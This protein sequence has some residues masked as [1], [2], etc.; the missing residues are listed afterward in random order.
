[1]HRHLRHPLSPRK[2][3]VEMVEDENGAGEIGRKRQGRRCGTTARA[4]TSREGRAGGVWHPKVA[5][6]GVG[7]R[8]RGVGGSFATRS[9]PR[10]FAVSSAASAALVSKSVSVHRR[11]AFARVKG[12]RGVSVMPA[13]AGHA[14]IEQGWV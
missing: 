6:T 5:R 9:V 14:A 4:A 1:M 2:K 3:W 12:A 13:A 10:F 8:R 7:R 11:R